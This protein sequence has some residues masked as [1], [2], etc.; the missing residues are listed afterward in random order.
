MPKTRLDWIVIT[1]IALTLGGVWIGSTRALPGQAT[2][3]ARSPA[4]EIGHPAPDFTLTSL[5]GSEV[6]LSDFQ[7]QPVVL[8]FWATWCPPCRAEMPA[9]QAASELLAGEAVVL[10]VSLQETSSAVGPFAEEFGITYPLVLDQSAQV[11]LTYRVSSIPTT[12]FIDEQGVVAEVFHSSLSEPL[13]L[14]RLDELSGD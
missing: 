5:D 7:G 4:P 10:G 6:S 11:A 1:I 14:A 9:L 13:I 2:P 12:F 3:A 8:N